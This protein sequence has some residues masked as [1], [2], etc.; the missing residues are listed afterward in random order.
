MTGNPWD[1]S[2][3][4]GPAPWDLG[5][6]QGAI[7][8]L[9]STGLFAGTVLDAGCGTGEH[10]MLIASLGLPVMGVDVAETAIAMAREKAQSRGLTVEFAIADALR[11]GRLERKFETVVDCGL[12]HTFDKE[13]QPR[14][15]ASLAS[16][17]QHGGNVHV[18]C[19][20]DQGSE[21]GPHPVRQEDLREA[22]HARMEWNVVSIE[23]ERIETRMHA[24]GVSAWLA[25]ISR[26]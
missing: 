18:L 8:R 7:A 17:T 22:F 9:A 21:I 11:L 26:I 20:S 13:E 12:F 5:R 1:A 25:K 16:V 19:F 24:N 23:P 2:Y 10:T 6:P 14:Y 4:S 15:A 3:Q